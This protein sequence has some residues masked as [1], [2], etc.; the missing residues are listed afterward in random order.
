MKE[1]TLTQVSACA[2]DLVIVVPNWME[3]GYSTFYRNKQM[4]KN[5][6]LKIYETA[7]RLIRIHTAETI[8]VT[9]TPKE[10]KSKIAD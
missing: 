8:T 9:K 2:D 5:T 3:L 4:V 6:K 1:Q 10:D 7:D